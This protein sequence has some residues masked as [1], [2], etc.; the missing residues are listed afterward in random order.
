MRLT[1]LGSNGTYPTAGRPASGFLVSHGTAKVWLDAGPGTFMALV[2][3]VDPGTLDGVVLSHAHPDHCTDLY[4]LV[5]YLGYGPGGRVPMPVFVPPGAADLLAAFAGAK[6]GGAFRATLEMQTV[7][8]GDSA[9][10]GD[11]GVRFAPANHSVPANVTRFEAGGRSLVYSGDTGLTAGL[12]ELSAD[13]D[14]LLCEATYQGPGEEKAYEYHLAASEAGA[15]ARRA[16]V[17]RL[18]L[19]HLTPTLDPNRSIA[20]AEAAFGRTVELAVP[21]MEVAV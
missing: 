10:I 6:E 2:E 9:S 8:A 14:V 15:V 16:G 17:S 19:T 20:E 12:D 13:A 5:H 21:G 1:V 4:A 7:T 11:L 3:R 18:I